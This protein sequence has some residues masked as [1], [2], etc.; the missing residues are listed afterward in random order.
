MNPDDAVSADVA[1]KRAPAELQAVAKYLRGKHGPKI[2]RG[3][4]NGSRHDYFKGKS[5]IKALLAPAYKKVK[6]APQVEN[7][8]E[9]LK[10]LITMLPYAFF[11]RVDRPVQ[12]PP[13]PAGQLRPLALA[14]QQGLEPTAYY[15]WLMASSPLSTYIG[16]AAMVAVILA[17]VMFPLW[18]PIMRQGV[19]YLSM[20]VLG[21]IGLFIAVG[22]VRLVIWLITRVL[23]K[24]AIWWFPNLFEDVGFVDSFIPFWGW[25]EPAQ[26]AAS[27]KSKS[28][29]SSKEKRSNK[30][31][32][33]ASGATA[34]ALIEE[35]SAAVTGASTP[36]SASENDAVKTNETRGLGDEPS[37]GAK[38][39]A[40]ASSK[41]PEME[42]GG[43]A[44]IRKRQLAYVEDAEE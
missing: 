26:S 14:K 40:A 25:D 6:K 42:I 10:L 11:L 8:E 29:K 5:A 27:G 33:S 39:S 15:V 24:K 7:E 21:L 32:S 12:D 19:S 22:V 37:T 31:K 9:A 36:I 43:D 18:P 13:T 41:G 1:Q 44:N 30:N 20:G 23:L 3:V 17:S 16:S 2:R 4:F 28:S 35:A 38:R 34:Q